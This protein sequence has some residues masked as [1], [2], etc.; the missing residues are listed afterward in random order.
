MF[1]AC[2]VRVLKRWNGR[3][4]SELKSYPKSA[5]ESGKYMS[6]EVRIPEALAMLPMEAPVSIRHCCGTGAMASRTPF[7]HTHSSAQST[8]IHH[9][10]MIL[11]CTCIPLSFAPPDLQTQPSS[12]NPATH[13]SNQTL[14]PIKSV[15]KRL[16][17]PANITR[18]Y[19]DVTWSIRVHIMHGPASQR[20]AVLYDHP[21]RTLTMP[22]SAGHA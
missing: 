5:M 15:I 18:H 2:T 11:Q 22:S 14:D 12:Q 19:T 16:V 13:P 21:H 7:Y 3:C 8:H 20:P 9:T 6:N 10:D 17:C 1:Y 4:V